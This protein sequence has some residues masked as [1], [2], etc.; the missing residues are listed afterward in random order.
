MPYLEYNL[1]RIANPNDFDAYQQELEHAYEH[2]VFMP[3]SGLLKDAWMQTMNILLPGKAEDDTIAGRFTVVL[4]AKA[5]EEKGKAFAKAVYNQCVEIFGMDNIFA[6]FCSMDDHFYAEDAADGDDTDEEQLQIICT[7]YMVPIQ[8]RIPNL[9][10]YADSFKHQPKRKYVKQIEQAVKKVFPDLHTIADDTNLTPQELGYQARLIDFK[11]H[12]E[13]K[14]DIKPLRYTAIDPDSQT[15]TNLASDQIR[16]IINDTV[17]YFTT[18]PERT[19]FQL[20]QTGELSKK[21]FFKLLEEYLDK[22]HDELSNI[23][24]EFI[25]KKL[26]KWAYGFYLLDPLIEDDEVSDIMVRVEFYS[27]QRVSDKQIKIIK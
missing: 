25:M 11:P 9:A 7:V 26:D 12:Q 19:S 20:A 8:K 1:K 27:K 22:N 23:D 4:H 16:K 14:S 18:G 24:R 5:T 17:A 15:Q 2:F 13:T 3:E 21:K 6:C 10:P